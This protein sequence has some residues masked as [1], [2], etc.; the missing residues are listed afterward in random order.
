MEELLRLTD[1]IGI[2]IE[3]GESHFREFKSALMGAADKKVSRDVKDVCKDIS[4]TLVAF[5]NA[6]GGELLVGVEDDGSIT[7]VHFSDAGIQALLDAPKKYV[8]QTTPLPTTKASLAEVEGKKILFFST[9]KGSDHVYLTSDGKCLQRKDLESIPISPKEIQFARDE[10]LSRQYDRSFV[11]NATI[12]DLD[13]ELV[14]FAAREFSKTITPEKFLQHLDLAEFDGTRLRLRKAALLLFAKNPLKWHPRCQVRILKVKGTELKSGI[15]YNVVKDQEVNDN[16]LKLIESSWDILRP[17][18]TETKLSSDAIFKTQVLFP[19]LAC[20][21]SLINAIAHRDYNIEGR[22][23]EVYIFDDRLEIK[24]PGELLTSI[25]IE[26]IKDQKGVHQSRNTHIARVLREVGYMRELGEGFRR[27]YELMENNDLTPPELISEDKSFIVILKHKLVYTDEER[28]WLENFNEVDLSREER[29]IV[30]LGAGGE[31]ISPKVI[32][33]TV[34]IVDTDDYRHL[35]E[36]LRRKGIL[37]SEVP[38]PEVL[39]IAKRNNIRNKK[40]I[41]RFR[42]IVPNDKRG[43]AKKKETPSSRKKSKPKFNK[44]IEEII[45]DSDYS[46]LYIENL[47][48][49]I[50]EEEI[51]DL[52][53]Q[54]GEISEIRIPKSYHSGK[55][56]GFGFIEFESDKA[57]ANVLKDKLQLYLGNR[58]VIVKRFDS[59]FGR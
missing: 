49:D 44:Q 19:E 40:T 5:A 50:T 1:R 43:L 33:E 13:I 35:I 42:I 38:K 7:G 36:Q 20:K 29:T 9:P 17:Y 25:S 53:E 54:Y 12:G 23:I 18:L 57:A 21:E 30:R 16:V 8:L 52:F 47:P 27:I 6:D 37:I 58:K 48:Y 34:G 24:S 15:E 39:K 22:G 3:M 51:A 31:L 28:I 46:K 11:D 32:W 14:T 59:K 55:G 26:D 10:K 41:P 45:D 2:A 4:K 56:R